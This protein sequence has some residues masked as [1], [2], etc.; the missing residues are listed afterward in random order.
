MSMNE[1]VLHQDLGVDQFVAGCIVDNINNPHMVCTTLGALEVARAQPQ[2]TVLLAASLHVDYVDRRQLIFSLLVAGLSL[3]PGLAV[4]GPV[5]L[6]DAHGLGLAGKVFFSV[7][8][9]HP[10]L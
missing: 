5:V 4:L 10:G 2:G 6:R 1:A 8:F 7:Q 3:V 9:C